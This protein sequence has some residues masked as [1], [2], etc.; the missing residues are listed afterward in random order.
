M[1]WVQRN[2]A[3]FGG[4]PS[5]VL[6]FGESAGGQAVCLHLVM[7]GSRGL[8]A[9]A[10]LQSADCDAYTQS[11]GAD[12]GKA[13]PEAVGCNVTGAPA[14]E[15]ACLREVDVSSDHWMD[16]ITVGHSLGGN[17]WSFDSPAA[18]NAELPVLPT[19]ASAHD[20]WSRDIPVLLGYNS[21]ESGMSWLQLAFENRLSEGATKD[22]FR[23]AL[24]TRYDSTVVDEIL[25][26]YAPDA[27]SSSYGWYRAYTR[28][29]GDFLM[30]C[31]GLEVAS[32]RAA[33]GWPTWL[34]HFDRRASCEGSAAS[35]GVV[36]GAE[37]AFVF[38]TPETFGLVGGPCAAFTEDEAELSA[39]MMGAWAALALHGDP[40]GAN[41]SS[42]IVWP[43]L[44]ASSRFADF[45]AA[46]LTGPGAVTEIGYRASTCKLVVD[47]TPQYYSG[48]PYTSE[49]LHV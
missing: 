10:A 16:L 37:V 32:I 5:R 40:N 6:L 43:R 48:L 26:A 14:E 38:G 12:R 33:A 36:H 30:K 20:V 31:S 46:R 21:D 13:I 22:E 15:L 4:D 9:A 39:A 11:Y 18:G 24:L 19:H 25:D 45:P 29:S 3:E 23:Q 41:S 44:P 27:G 8:F 35:A 34:Y 7:H 47:T 28:F 17:P 42:S 2:I 49:S 1:Q